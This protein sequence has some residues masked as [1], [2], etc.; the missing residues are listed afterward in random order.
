MPNLSRHS[1]RTRL[2]AG[3]VGASVLS[4]WLIVFFVG[5]YLRAD[6]EGAISAQQYST[7]SLIA[8]EIERSVDERSNVLEDLSRRLA[9]S[10]IVHSSAQNLLEAQSGLEA[11]FNW[12]IIVLDAEGT[13]IASTPPHLDRTG[14]RYGDRGFFRELQKSGQKLITEP[15]I[16]RR[17][18]V[19]VITIAIPVLAPNQ[20]M[21]GAVLGVT[22]LGIPNFLDEIS[23]AKYGRTGDFFVTETRARMFIASSDQQRVL[24]NG[25]PPGVNAVYDSYIDGREGSGVAV[26]SRGVEELSSS[27]R[28]A[29]TSWLM[30]SVLPTEEAFAVIRQMQ[31]RL[32]AAAL[33]FTLVAGMIAWWWVRRQLQP[34]ERSAVLLDEMR[35]GKRARTPLP[36]ESDDEIG[37]LTNAFNGLLKSIVDQEAL[38]ARVAAT[39]LLRK[40]LAHVPGMVFQYYQHADGTGAFPFASAA[41]R[42][43]YGISPEVIE[44]DASFIRN[45]LV[46]EDHERLFGSLHESAEKMSRWIVDYRIRMPDGRLKWLH[47]DAMPEVE[48]NRIV[49]YGF[50]TDV[51]ATHALEEELEIHRSHLEELVR[52]RTEQLEEARR[53]AE[54]A[55][56]AKSSFLANMSH[57]IRTPMNA[58]IGL[59]GLL[60]RSIDNTEQRDMLAKIHLA[61]DH[62][63]AII[64]DVLDISKIEAGKI[65]LE[66]IEFD[67]GETVSRAAGLIAGKV[68]E[69]GI[70]FTVEL[71]QPIDGCLRGDPTRLAQALLNYLGNA[72]KFTE[73]GSITLRAL[74]LEQSADSAA[75]RFEVRDSGIGIPADALPTLFGA[76]EQA[77]RSTT[78]QYGGTGLGLAITRQL[79]RMMGGDAGVESNEG[80]G[81]SFWF[82][83]RFIRSARQLAAATDKRASEASDALLRRDYQ[84][85]QILLCEDNPVNQEVALALLQEVGMQV[86]I[87]QNG[88]EAVERMASQPFALILMDMQMPVMDGLEATRRIR[89]RPDGKAIPILAMTANAFTEDMARC[90]E[91][92]MN[93]FVAKPVEPDLL[94]GKLLQWLARS[95]QTSPASREAAAPA[96]P[97]DD[98]ALQALARLPEI[99]LDAALSRLRGNPQRLLKLLHLFVAEHRNDADAL[100]HALRDG[101]CVSAERLAHTLKGAAGSLGLERIR[102]AATE[103]NALLRDDVADHRAAVL[104]ERIADALQAFAA[105]LDHL[106]EAS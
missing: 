76:F 21:I 71:P 82:T 6:M 59:S 73:R 16:G 83:A 44:A 78:R 14:T 51:T 100:R 67:L 46:A 8:S 89:A 103:L 57:E 106:D 29:G 23:R 42:D 102:Q 50:V 34:L 53:F 69:K 60:E 64:N 101:D 3:V 37:Q 52:E 65:Q 33:T 36:V 31:Y 80:E 61:A 58:I 72:V 18:S 48:D 94:F 81:S 79:A 74:L 93:D 40:T 24:K 56:Q 77:D 97:P 47:V 11:L 87:A 19:P 45:M 1:L 92:G 4:V 88:A 26:S 90:R 43:I 17:T 98:A 32:F 104:T 99:D 84:G 95:G 62:L 75:Y 68:A 9:E 96:I 54:S 35:Q 5:K 20:R 105:A 41:V 91:A 22:N 66:D 15:L 85:S 7:V 2:V 70:R 30:Q 55:S 27:V 12:G 38:L 25:P 63:L 28:I 13:A 49:W 39:E 10:G 86:T